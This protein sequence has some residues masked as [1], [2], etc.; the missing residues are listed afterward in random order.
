MQYDI[1]KGRMADPGEEPQT[2]QEEPPKRSSSS[3]GRKG[4]SKTLSSAREATP[5]AVESKAKR[6]ASGA[7]SKKKLS[8]TSRLRGA[9]RENSSPAQRI[10]SDRDSRGDSRYGTE[11]VKR[12]SSR[13][14]EDEDDV[15]STQGAMQALDALDTLL[16]QTDAHMEAARTF[17]EQMCRPLPPCLPFL[18]VSMSPTH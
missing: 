15:G 12:V 7:A 17:P 8:M 10:K 11:D 16:A 4:L 18:Y 1:G 13:L 6:G 3:S 5:T 9:V 14:D 2:Q